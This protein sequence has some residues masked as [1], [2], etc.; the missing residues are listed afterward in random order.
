MRCASP[1]ESVEASRS[2]VRYSSPTASRKL[3]RCRTSSRIGPAISSCIGDNSSASKEL[4]ALAQSSAPSPGRCSARSAAPRAPRPAAAA[5]GN[6][7]T[8]HSRDT[9]SASRARAACTSCAP[10][11]RRTRKRPSKLPLPRS[12]ISR[13]ASVISRHGTS[14]G[15]PSAAACLL[16]LGEPAA[17]TSADSTDR[18]RRR[19]ASAP[20]RE[21]RGSDRSRPCCR[22]PGSA[23]T[24]Q[25]DC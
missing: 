18:S 14:S 24:R 5:R 15:T 16:Q 12:T 22:I 13:A 2:S 23:D 21:S 8:P 17:G 6:P 11:A 7:D 4:L 19:S 10:S 20:C 25:T 1:P 3:S 9:C